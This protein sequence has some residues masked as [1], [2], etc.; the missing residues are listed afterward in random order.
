MQLFTQTIQ[1]IIS[2]CIAQEAIIWDDRNSPWIDEKIKKL[3]FH[4]N[5]VYSMYSRDI[6]NTDLF[7]KFQS[8]QVDLKTTIEESK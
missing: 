1:N 5:C 7:N 3:V 6:N 8:L 4:K 2:N